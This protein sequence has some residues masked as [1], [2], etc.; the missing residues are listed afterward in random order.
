MSTVVANC[1]GVYLR[2]DTE[3]VEGNIG[4]EAGDIEEGKLALEPI[5]AE[6]E[7]HNLLEIRGL[8]ETEFWK[9]AEGEWEKSAKQFGDRVEGK[10]TQVLNVFNEI[11]QLVG[12]S[13][14]FQGL[15]LTAASQ[16]T[17]LSCKSKWWVLTLSLFASSVTAA[18]VWQKN[19]VISDLPVSLFP[20]P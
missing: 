10:K 18:G 11:Y 1:V 3:L 20:F 13:S 8:P 19:I 15:L 17:W 12:F 5:Y 16:G 14:T 7:I 4:G 2:V 9:V 6:Q